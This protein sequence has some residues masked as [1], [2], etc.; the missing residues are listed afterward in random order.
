M[1]PFGPHS[2]LKLVASDVQLISAV[3]DVKEALTSDGST[4]DGT[5]Q[6]KFKTIS[7][8]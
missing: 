8:F 7:P 3:V 5:S 4:Q 2:T 6:A 1:N